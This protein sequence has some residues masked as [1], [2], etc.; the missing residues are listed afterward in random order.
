MPDAVQGNDVY[1][2]KMCSRLRLTY[3]VK[4]LTFMVV[5][6]GMRLNIIVKPDCDVPED[7]RD[8]LASHKKHVRLERR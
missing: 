8:H 4:L 2:V 5:E 3:Q 7:L 1:I 6:K